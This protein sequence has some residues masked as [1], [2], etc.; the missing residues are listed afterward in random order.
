MF[1]NW[2]IPGS[3]PPMG[4]YIFINKVSYS[5]VL[6]S[7]ADLSSVYRVH[8]EPLDFRVTSQSTPNK[9]HEIHVLLKYLLI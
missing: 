7:L 9:Q 5:Y 4:I 6:I 2:F 8:N 3:N 1:E